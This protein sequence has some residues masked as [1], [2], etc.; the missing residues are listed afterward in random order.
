MAQ[1]GRKVKGS[2]VRF[3]EQG[4]KYNCVSRI[5]RV[6]VCGESGKITRIF[7]KKVTAFASAMNFFF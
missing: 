2:E 3:T 7:S 1:F 6:V 5:V 4:V